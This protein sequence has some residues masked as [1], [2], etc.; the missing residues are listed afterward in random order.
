M[1]PSRGSFWSPVILAGLAGWQ[2]G[3]PGKPFDAEAAGIVAVVDVAVL[4]M[5]SEAVLRGQTVIVRNSLIAEVGPADAVDVP[6]GA[7]R[8]DGVGL[9]LMPGLTDAHVHLRDH[10]ELLSYLAYGVTTVV[11]LGGPTGNIPDVVRLR[12]QVASGAVPGPNIYT[13]GRMLDGDPPVFPGV[14]T[15]VRTPAEAT[16]AVEGQLEDSVDLIKVY[17]NLRTEQLQA[18]TRAAHERD[19]MVWGHVPRIDGRATALQQALAAGLDVMV[20]GEEVFF[21]MLY[22]DVEAQLDQG[23]VP[24][25]DVALMRAAVRAIRESDVAVIPNLSFV[26]MTR[27]QL[28]DV[29]QVWADPETRFLN[30]TVLNMWRQQNPTR[31]AD[32]ERFNRRER[33]KQAIVRQLTGALQ[34]AGVPMLLGTDASAPG[35]FPGKSAHLELAELVGAGLTPYQ[36]LAAG[37]SNPGRLVGQRVRRSPAFGTVTIGSRADLVLLTANPL[38]DIAHVSRLVGVMVRGEWYARGRIDS[39]RAPDAAEP[40][41]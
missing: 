8:I 4:P 1:I 3:A 17:N 35:M 26:A 10:G 37:T 23:L 9:Y 33:G 21:T 36:A 14:S 29:E 16:R 2:C 27:V 15:V 28:D 19:V 25:P 12:E 20:H 11:H 5:D 39:L 30:P 18:V 38:T 24:T 31:R 32:L 34:E 6:A 13:A 22:R 7:Q 41:R 40:R